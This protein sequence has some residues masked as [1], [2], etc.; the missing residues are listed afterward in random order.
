MLSSNEINTRKLIWT[1]SAAEQK[2]P[3]NSWYPSSQRHRF[4]MQ[5]EWATIQFTSSSHISPRRTLTWHLWK[6]LTE[7]STFRNWSSLNDSSV[8][9]TLLMSWC[10]CSQMHVLFAPHTAKLSFCWHWE[11]SW[12]GWYSVDATGRQRLRSPLMIWL[13]RHLH[14]P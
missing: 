13:V 8:I 7:I 5:L 9:L 3:R 1:L 2:R 6:M 14:T 11:C 4:S 12:H 10:W